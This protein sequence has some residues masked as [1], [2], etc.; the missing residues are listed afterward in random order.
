MV[1]IEM[2]TE[3][4]CKWTRDSIEYTKKTLDNLYDQMDMTSMPLD[5]TKRAIALGGT[6]TAGFDPG[7]RTKTLSPLLPICE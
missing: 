4:G 2:K 1:M 3:N 5:G 7:W 6:Q